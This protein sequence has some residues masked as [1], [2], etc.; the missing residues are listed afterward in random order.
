MAAAVARRQSFRPAASSSSRKFPSIDAIPISYL[1]DGKE[2]I[3][4]HNVDM[5]ML[6]GCVALF[7]TRFFF[8]YAEIMNNRILDF[9]YSTMGNEI[10]FGVDIHAFLGSGEL[11]GLCGQKIQCM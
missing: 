5:L 4:D 8:K 7:M 6:D 2:W 3:A 11:E 1:P 10:L 9:Y